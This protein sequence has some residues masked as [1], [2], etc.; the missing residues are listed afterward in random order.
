M[1]ELLAT[2]CELLA[3]RQLKAGV[4]WRPVHPPQ[5]LARA[6]L[7]RFEWPE[8]PRLEGVVEGPVLR[9]DG[10]VLQRPGFDPASG[11]YHAPRGTFEPVPEAPTEE[12]REMALL[13]LTEAVCDFPFASEAHFSAWLAALLTPLARFAFEGPSPVNL[14]DANVR[15]AGKS[16][17]ADVCHLL[18]TGRPAARMAYVR[19]EAEL[20]KEITSIALKA[21]Q[22]VVIDNVSGPFG[23]PTLDLALTTMSWADRLLGQNLDLELPL[24][25]TWYVTGNNIEL[26]GDMP[27]RCLHVRLESPE[28]KPEHRRGFRHPHLMRWLSAERPRLLPAALTLLAAYHAAGR[29]DQGLRPWGSFE[30]WSDLIRGTLV[31]LGLPDPA[32]TCDQLE[33]AADAHSAALSRLLQ[34]LDELLASL[35]GAATVRKILRTLE[36]NGARYETLRSAL[37]DVFPRLK[38][39]DLPTPVKLGQ[40]LRSLRGRVLGGL[41][42]V[43]GEKTRQGIAWTVEQRA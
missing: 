5:W 36:E 1:R 42:A 12:E 20:R 19:D 29:P 26:V 6:L 35:G 16:L 21:R 8:L 40:K 11:L 31:W 39:G 13:R 9:A 7:G 34:G 18:V 38:A 33:S 17:L 27:R 14:I 30:S 15:G 24:A 3:A 41:C 25:I 32:A 2:H 43:P 28:E 10:S 37:E 23:S 4:E 22:L